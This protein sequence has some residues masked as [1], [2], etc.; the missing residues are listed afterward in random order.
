MKKIDEM[1]FYAL[2]K[3]NDIK[4]P[5]AEFLFAKELKRKFRF[6]YCFIDNKLAVEIEGGVWINGRHNRP[7][8]FIKDMEKYNLAC[9]LGY[10]ILRFTISDLKKQTTYELINKCLNN[11]KEN[12]NAESKLWEGAQ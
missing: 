8:G 5:V 7:S 4:M 1:I 3:K 10:R 12:Y 11:L 2:L 9:M 6:D